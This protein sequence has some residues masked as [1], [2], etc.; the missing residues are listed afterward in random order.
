LDLL[1]RNEPSRIVDVS[2][3]Y[4]SKGEIYFT[5]I[6]LRQKYSL[7]LANNQSKLANV[8]FTYKLVR[9]LE[10]TEVRINTLHPGAVNTGSIL[11]SEDFSGFFKLFY[12]IM[13]V[14]FKSPEQGA[15]TVVY[16][17]SSP[18]VE[19]ISGQYFVDEKPRKS[20]Q[21]TYDTQL[22]DKLWDKSWKIIKELNL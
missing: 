22:Q 9:D 15:A 19:G 16:L 10:G 21:K 1:K 20:A 17:A 3:M 8:L 18:E 5:D 14:F 13:S 12:R 4:H 7:S 2:G 11:R 6:N